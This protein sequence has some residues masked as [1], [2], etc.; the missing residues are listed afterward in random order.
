MNNK[1]LGD[2]DLNRHM[3]QVICQECETTKDEVTVPG[4][5]LC[6]NC[7]SAP[8]SLQTVFPRGQEAEGEG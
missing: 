5:R 7:D 6:P 3:L 4:I 1:K 2:G 8:L